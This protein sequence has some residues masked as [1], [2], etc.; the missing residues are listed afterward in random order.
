MARGDQKERGRACAERAGDHEGRADPDCAPA[1]LERK[2]PE[3]VAVALANKFARLAWW[4]TVS[5]GVYNR[6]PARTLAA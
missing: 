2:P 1:L 5:G 4:L 6:P 3:L